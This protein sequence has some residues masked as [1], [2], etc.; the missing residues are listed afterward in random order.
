[1]LTLMPTQFKQ[2][3]NWLQLLANATDL[4]LEVGNLP[5][6]FTCPISGWN[7]DFSVASISHDGTRTYYNDRDNKYRAG[8][9]IYNR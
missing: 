3:N 7:D 9:I 4:G 1:M 5:S 8:I 6:E 2:D